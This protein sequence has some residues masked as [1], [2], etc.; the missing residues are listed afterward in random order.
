[1][2]NDGENTQQTFPRLIYSPTAPF[3]SYRHEDIVILVYL[4]CYDLDVPDR[5]LLLVRGQIRS[6]SM[7]GALKTTFYAAL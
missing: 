1:M 6:M 3:S 5:Q 2:P 7:Y 4:T